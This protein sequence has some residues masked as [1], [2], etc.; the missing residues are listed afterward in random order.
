MASLYLQRKELVYYMGVQNTCHMIGEPKP[1]YGFS[2]DF[3]LKI[4]IVPGG[5]TLGISG[6]GCAAG[7]LEPLTFTRASSAEFCYPIL[8]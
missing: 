6:W 5:D 4:V 3:L 1:L 7:S 2:I 8:E